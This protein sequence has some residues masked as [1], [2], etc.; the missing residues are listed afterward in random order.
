MPT[1]PF[2]DWP[3]S[4]QGCLAVFNQRE[5]RVLSIAHTAVSRETGRLRYHPFAQIPGLDVHLLAPQRWRQFGRDITADPAGDPG[6][7]LHLERILLSGLPG[8]Q[9]Y[10]HVY[11]RLHRLIRSIQPDVIHL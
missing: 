10:A 2:L 3:A 9:W 1:L 11:P 5:L 6:I 8:A 4:E 7:S